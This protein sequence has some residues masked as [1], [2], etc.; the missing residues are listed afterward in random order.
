MA[1]Q[2]K[3]TPGPWT[4]SRDRYNPLQ[5]SENAVSIDAETH[6]GLAGVWVRMED[7]ATDDPTMV[8]NAHLIAAAPDL[9]AALEAIVK[10]PDPKSGTDIW[11]RARAAAGR[12]P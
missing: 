1:T 6:F 5:H 3:W 8:A 12:L 9:Y 2:T 10:Y 7:E 11:I 4:I